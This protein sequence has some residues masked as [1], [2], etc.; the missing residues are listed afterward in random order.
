MLTQEQI[1][2]LPEDAQK[3]YMQTMLLLDKKEKE[4]AIRD[5]FLTFVKHM[6][7]EFIPNQNLLLTICR[8]G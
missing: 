6:W 2:N 3:E 4:Q 7:P 5:D 1:K 8:R